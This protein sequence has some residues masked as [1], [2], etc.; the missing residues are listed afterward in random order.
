[1]ASLKPRWN[2][3]LSDL[4]DNKIRSALVIA[5]ITVGV[6]AAGLIISIYG[7]LTHDMRISYQK[8]NPANIFVFSPNFDT[9][10][11]DTINHM[12]EIAKAEAV[13]T[14]TLQLRVD[15]GQNNGQDNWI[16]INVKAIPD[17][18]KMDLNRVTVMQGQWPPADKQ[19][20][21]DLHKYGDAHTSIGSVVEV[22]LPD[23]KIRRMPVVGLV[24]DQTIG[25]ASSS[26]GYFAS[27]LQA[28]VTFD[29]L[30]WLEQNKS[31]NMLLA[32]VSSAGENN[33]HIFEVARLISKKFEDNNIAINYFST[34]MTS[35][36]P[37]VTYIDAISG[38]LIIL[39]FLV[40][41]L[42]AFLITNTLSSLLSQQMEQIGIIKTLGG[43]STQII[44]IF[45]ALILVF[46]LISLAIALP[47]SSILAYVLLSFLA[48]QINFIPQEFRV[49]P[50]SVF[51]EIVIALI[52]PQLAGF[53]PI[54]RGSL[55]T[56][57]EAINGSTGNEAAG[58]HHWVDKIINSLKGISRPLLISL[59][60]TFRRKS[61]LILTLVTLTL[62][63]AMF[64][65]TF[66]VQ[67]SMNAFIDK[68]SHYF[69][70]DVTLDFDQAYDISKIQTMLKSQPEIGQVEGWAA[71]RGE[72]M[73]AGDKPGESI[74]LIA[75]PAD[76]K[77][78]QPVL[79][80]G[81][82]LVPGDQ[83]AIAVNEK[84]LGRFPDLKLGD[85]LR[86]R[87]YGKKVD[88]V[89]VGIFQF[90]GKSA[91]MVGYA[92]YDYLSQITHSE[93][94]ASSF[95]IMSA[96]P[97]LTL[98]EQKELGT[99]IEKY[100]TGLGYRVT[101]VSAG[102]SLIESAASGLNVLIIFLLIMALLAAFVGS[103]GLTGTLSMNVLDR[104]REIAVMRA[105]GAS[106]HDIIRL[107]LVEGL[108]I[109]LISWALGS[110]LAFPI[111]ELLWNVISQALF[112]SAS[113]F[114]F[115]MTGFI[116]WMVVE[117]ILATIASVIPALNAARLT[118]RE[119]LA[120]E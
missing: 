6:F 78:I 53:F 36:H 119:A 93:H 81:R 70:A 105:I 65:A 27:N 22:K 69:A 30:E 16:T 2:K 40:V 24:Q 54:L 71:A 73:L 46:S 120:Y 9:K 47:S 114:T 64:I 86:V 59:R 97:K 29:T 94:K 103:I 88:W 45:M 4:L 39:G 23:D 51:A 63:G 66:N 18:N 33:E 90:A 79:L 44:T 62:G 95:R 102:Q 74:N 108:L 111:S 42:S 92:N 113:N 106:D 109:G 115:N 49:I 12:P 26:G 10:F 28:Y 58:K 83:N 56:V 112:D 117:L 85:T 21:F 118:I 1:M 100:F 68:L 72:L 110:L 107:V 32:S 20:V 55:T 13:R 57:Q 52:V 17:F 8:T 84:F 7:I 37:N 43:R 50:E 41:F 61:R 34:R 80:Q 77:L 15:N 75:P 96:K 101:N 89:V 19:L 35:E 67:S 11:T 82:W 14:F 60:N 5:S 87:I 76:S 91:G 3:V 38:I 48:K 116:L 25:A 99:T 104:T 31:P 98:A